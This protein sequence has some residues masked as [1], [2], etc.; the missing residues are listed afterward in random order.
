VSSAAP[1][2]TPAA[3]LLGSVWRNS[4]FRRIWVGQVISE[5]A[6]WAA[7]LAMSILVFTATEFGRPAVVSRG[8]RGHAGT[9]HTGTRCDASGM[10]M[11]GCA[12]GA[13]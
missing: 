2:P 12:G 7:R 11:R 8:L 6:D 13:R 9:C 10:V 5:V 1:A 3:G 4:A